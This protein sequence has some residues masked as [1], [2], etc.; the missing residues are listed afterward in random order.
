MSTFNNNNRTKNILMSSTIGMVSDLIRILLAFVYRSLF[1]KFLTAEYLGINGLFTNILTILSLAELGITTSITFRF[2]EPISR[3]DVEQVG[4]LMNFFKSVYNKIA[5]FIL[6]IGIA[7]IPFLPLFISDVSTVPSD[8]NIY[9]VYILFL[10]NTLSSYI[11]VYKLTILSADQKPYIQNLLTVITYFFSYI[12]QILILFFTRNYTLTLIAGIV[13]NLL[14]NYIASCWVTKE[15]SAVF[16]VESS[17][18]KKEEHAIFNETKILMYHKIGTTVLTGTD[19]VI[20]SKFVSLTATGLYSNYSMIISNVVTLFSKL[21]GNF[22]SSMANARLTMDYDNYYKSYK[23]SVFLNLVFACMASFCLYTCI[24]D[25]INIW[26]GEKYVFNKAVTFVLC[27]Q[28][29]LT[30][31][32]IING[33]FTNASGLFIKDK[34]RPLIESLINLVVS[35]L[36]TLKFGIVGVFLGTVISNLCTVWWRVPYLLYEYEFKKNSLLDYWKKY[37]SFFIVYLLSCALVDLIKGTV[38]TI[39]MNLVL[40]FVEFFSAALFIALVV[41]I[42]FFKTDEY[43]FIIKFISKFIGKLVKK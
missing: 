39:K 40:I 21:L 6:V 26:I 42:L 37:F 2:Y 25:F 12:C 31:S 29:Y 32:G 43:K 20:L 18:T 34:Y 27:I 24:D 9:V 8:I 10:I 35:I 7:L 11:F 30:A 19:N 3:N 38:L 16:E 36:L 23:R 17:I 33:V 5:I 15:Y 13:I 14:I 4:K 28:F 22:V 1:L 41:S